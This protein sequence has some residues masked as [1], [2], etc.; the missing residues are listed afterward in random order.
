MSSTG[1]DR[2]LR[3]ID[4][5]PTPFHVVTTVAEE[6]D[7]AGFTRLDERDEWPLGPGAHYVVRGGSLI[8]WRSSGRPT[9]GFRIVGGHTDSP[10]LRLKQRHD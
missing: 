4:E 2:I 9:A 3:F 8:A 5:S 1:A 7:G 10:N 6:L